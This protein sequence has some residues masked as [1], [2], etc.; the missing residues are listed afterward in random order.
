[1]KKLLSKPCPFC[2]ASIIGKKR[3]DR[4]AYH[5]A[6][7]CPN[8]AYKALT[9]E[10]KTVRKQVL[11]KIRVSLPV[12]SKRL[13]KSGNGL[14][15]VQVKTAEPN[16]WDYEHRV[17]ANAPKG[18]HVHHINENTQDNRI[19]NLRL[20]TPQEH[21]DAHVV[22]TWAKKYT[23]CTTCGTTEKRHLSFGLCTTCYQR[24][25]KPKK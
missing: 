7:R 3:T 24:R 10:I 25:N 14:V 22:T 16:K 2:G 4:N 18:V 11:D 23:C 1:M 17:V 6:P 8:C 13:H 20:V 12:G 9:P 21:R 15:Y 5:Y 19:E